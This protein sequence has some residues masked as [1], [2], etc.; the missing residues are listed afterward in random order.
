MPDRLTVYACWEKARQE[1]PDDPERRKF[2]YVELMRENAHLVPGKPE[3]LPCGW[4]WR[5]GK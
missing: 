1:F 2:R 4:D 5:A 3:P